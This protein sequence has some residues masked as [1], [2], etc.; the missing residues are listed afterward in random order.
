MEMHRQNP[1]NFSPSKSCHL[2]YLNLYILILTK[3]RWQ[4]QNEFMT[5]PLD[6]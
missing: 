2:Y 4:Q 6:H 1:L 3:L 5:F